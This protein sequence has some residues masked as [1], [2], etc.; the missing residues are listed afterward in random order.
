VRAAALSVAALL[1]ALC[2]HASDAPPLAHNPF[3]RPRLEAQAPPAANP[4]SPVLEL[5]AILSAGQASRVDV[6]GRIVAIG[7][8]IDGYRLVS[9]TEDGAVFEH[10]GRS[11]RVPMPVRAAVSGDAPS[12]AAE[13]SGDAD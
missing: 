8:E 4:A 11:V 12:P 10:G 5:R 9:V 3:L 2:V 7:G 1:G 13:E 6:G